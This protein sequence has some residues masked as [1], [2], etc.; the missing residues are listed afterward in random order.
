M[1]GW[2]ARWLAGSYLQPPKTLFEALALVM[3]RSIIGA[4]TGGLIFLE[5][6]MLFIPQEIS[7]TLFCILFICGFLWGFKLLDV[8]SKREDRRH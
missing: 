5:P 6:S 8:F 2:L 3:L 7:I 4:L 1:S